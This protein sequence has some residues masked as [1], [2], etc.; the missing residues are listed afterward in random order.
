MNNTSQVALGQL[1]SALTTASAVT[2]PAGKTIVAITILAASQNVTAISEDTS[3]FP[4]LSA[5]P[6]P[7]GV[8][9]YGRYSN[10]LTSSA[11]GA[12]YYFG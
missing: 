5:L 7:E 12:I 4:S 11:N 6:V 2:P 9:I 8:T 1:G 3:L 10:I